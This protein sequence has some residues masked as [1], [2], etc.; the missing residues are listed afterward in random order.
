MNNNAPV[1]VG[2]SPTDTT[3]LV[4]GCYLFHMVEVDM[5]V[6]SVAAH[7]QMTKYLLL[8]NQK[9][10]LSYQW[11]HDLVHLYCL[12]FLKK[13]RCP[14]FSCKGSSSTIST[15]QNKQNYIR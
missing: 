1:D 13:M 5:S 11:E 15:Q 3:N 12:T 9:S 2:A 8:D 10:S 14:N 4:L 6:L 7:L